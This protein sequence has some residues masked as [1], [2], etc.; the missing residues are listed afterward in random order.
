LHPVVIIVRRI[1]DR[2]KKQPRHCKWVKNFEF[3]ATHSWH[4]LLFPHKMQML[5][6]TR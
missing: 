2:V 4:Y 6:F 5:S 3:I 1:N